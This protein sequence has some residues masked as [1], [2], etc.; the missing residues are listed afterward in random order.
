ME[1]FRYFDF[2]KDGRL[3]SSDFETFEESGE[4]KLSPGLEL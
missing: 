2:N 1:A 3:S 4:Y